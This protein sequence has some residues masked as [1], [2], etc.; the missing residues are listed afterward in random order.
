MSLDGLS[1]EFTRHGRD[2]L[3][4]H[5]HAE[6]YVSI[7]L[8]GGYVEAG[9]GGRTRAQ[10]G[11]VLVHGA[12]AAHLNVFEASRTV[13]LNLVGLTSARVIR[14]GIIDDVDAVARAAERDATAAVMLVAGRVRPEETRLNDWPDQLA[15]A[16][17]TDP[18][19]S[20][21]DWANRMGL[22]P[23]SVSRGFR[24]CFGVS[25][26]SFRREA[27]TRNALCAITGT[28]EQLAHVAADC[29]FADQA[30]LS[31]ACRELA[32]VTPA[33]LRAKSV[34]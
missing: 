22:N 9:D 7:V 21:T 19:L 3:P 23:A 14:A 26:K 15:D 29:G 6:P 20:I 31:R 24:R 1:C 2:V 17:S 12:Y 18:A 5:H 28:R 34:Q 30:H 13:V 25:P 32:G 8:V 4:R 33:T 11:S 27:R 10:P 16:L